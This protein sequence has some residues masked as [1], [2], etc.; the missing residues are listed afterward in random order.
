MTTRIRPPAGNDVTKLLRWLFLRTE[1]ELLNE[2][3]RKRESGYV[4]YAEVAAMERVQ[5]I[6]QDMVDESWAY[7]PEMVEKIF[8]HSNK[9]AAGYANAR[10][11]TS[12]QVNVV[13][14]LSN[15]L[16]G[17]LMEAAGTAQ[18]TVENVFAV[19]RLENDKFRELA[20]KQVLRE[21]AAGSP[22]IKNSRQLVQELQSKGITAFVDKAGRRWSL[23]SYANMAVRTTA[24]Q[25]EIAALLTADEHDLWQIAKIGSTCPVCAPLEG[26]VYSKS[27]QN[28]EYPPLTL[29]FGKVDPAGGDDLMNTYLNVHPNCLHS[30]LKYTTIGKSEKQ[31][32]KDKDFSNPEKNPLNRDPRTKKQ[33]KAYQDKV[34]A[35]QRLLRDMRQHKEYRA[36]L[37]KDVPKDFAKFREMK[38]NEGEKWGKV[39]KLYKGRFSLQERLDYI[40]YGE[41]LFI[42]QH[43]KFENVRTIAGAGSETVLR[44]AE[45]LAEEYGG[46]AADWKKRVGKI[47]SDKYVFDIHWYELNGNQYRVKVKDRRDKK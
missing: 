9:A 8:Y 22:W 18:K 30:I 39:Q 37:G 17:K 33:I 32:Q 38:Y 42:P 29:A 25:A 1:R 10:V 46:N 40:M 14:Q 12:T 11:L 24:R 28:T 41:R 19:G 20:L 5:K 31:I 6:L 16:L 26:R 36:A 7:I 2:I 21:E 4:D 3:S 27:G 43:S 23:Q 47:E 34:K 45:Q 13:Q 44:I 15:N 35:R